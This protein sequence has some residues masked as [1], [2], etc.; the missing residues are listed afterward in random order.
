MAS[1]GQRLPL[2]QERNVSPTLKGRNNNDDISA[3]QALY[4]LSRPMG[5]REARRPWLSY[6]APWGLRQVNAVGFQIL[7]SPSTTWTESGEDHNFDGDSMRICE[8]IDQWH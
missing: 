4:L 3:L 7:E 8:E 2:R 6:F 5:K 1:S